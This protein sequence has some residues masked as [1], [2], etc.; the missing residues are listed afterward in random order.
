[1]APWHDCAPCHFRPDGGN[2]PADPPSG[3]LNVPA[4][5]RQSSPRRALLAHCLSN[6]VRHSH[7]GPPSTCLG[8][9]LTP[10][11]SPFIGIWPGPFDF[12]Y[13]SSLVSTQCQSLRWIRAN[14]RC[15]WCGGS[16]APDLDGDAYCIMCG[17]TKLQRP[18]TSFEMREYVGMRRILTYGPAAALPAHLPDSGLQWVK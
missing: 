3:Q 5:S 17:R 18:P 12:P 16:M 13:P 8:A 10:P 14:Q 4:N 6:Y 11:S 7:C 9:Y 1:M 2:Q 15:I